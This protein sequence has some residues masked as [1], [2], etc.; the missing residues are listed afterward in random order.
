MTRVRWLA[1]GRVCGTDKFLR[2][3]ALPN[4][5]KTLAEEEISH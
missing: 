5:D 3:F 1:I 2:M 4:A